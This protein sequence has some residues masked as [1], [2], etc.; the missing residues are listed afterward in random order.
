MGW[1]SRPSVSF[2]SPSLFLPLSNRF[3]CFSSPPPSHHLHPT[4]PPNQNNTP[5]PPP[6]LFPTPPPKKKLFETFCC[7]SF[8]FFFF[9][10]FSPPHIFK[11]NILE[12]EDLTKEFAGFIAVN[13]VSL[14]VKRGTIHALD[15]AERRRQDHLLQSAHQIPQ[16]HPRPHSVQGPRYHRDAAGRRGAARPG[17]LVPD[18]RG[19]PA[20]ER[21]GKRAHRAAAQPRRL[22]RFLALDLGAQQLQRAGDGADR[23]CRPVL[24]R[25]LDRGRIALWPQARARDRHHAGARSGNAAA[26]R[27]DR[28]HGA[29]GHRPHQRN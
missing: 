24:V 22:V 27:A 19:V 29:R 11:S 12:T 13:G 2:L 7:P 9:F 21:A 20:Y 5:P 8:F 10:F 25:R 14:R 17:A 23:R 26:R 4:P 1:T 3:L 16:P 6:H 18:F 28:R 15:R